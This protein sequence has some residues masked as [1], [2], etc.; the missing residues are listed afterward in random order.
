MTK[1]RRRKRREWDRS[2]RELQRLRRSLVV[3]VRSKSQLARE[4]TMSWP[5]LRHRYHHTWASRRE[6][7]FGFLFF[8]NNTIFKEFEKNE[9]NKPPHG[10]L[11]HRIH[12]GSGGNNR[13]QAGESTVPWSPLV[14]WHVCPLRKSNQSPIHTTSQML[15]NLPQASTKKY[16]TKRDHVGVPILLVISPCGSFSAAPGDCNIS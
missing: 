6:E 7:S 16:K 2:R 3:P 12:A 8:Q 14:L 1:K 11:T 4:T 10:I 15:C 9:K 13:P 5:Q